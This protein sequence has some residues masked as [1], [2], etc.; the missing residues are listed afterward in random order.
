MPSLKAEKCCNDGTIY[1]D[2][3]CIVDVSNNAIPE[4]QPATEGMSTFILL[5]IRS[6]ILHFLISRTFLK[7]PK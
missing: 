3:K 1:V 2:G 4:E 6:I 5:A 7:C